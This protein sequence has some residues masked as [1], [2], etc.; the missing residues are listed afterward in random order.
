MELALVVYLIGILPSVA[1]LFVG[2][3]VIFSALTAIVLL[4][5]SLA[6]EGQDLGKFPKWIP[7]V[8]ISLGFVAA[9]L[10]SEKTA[11]MMTAAY[12]TQKVVESP[13]V[14]EVGSKL[15]QA[16]NNN[17]DKVITEAEKDK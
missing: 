17:L 8:A 9:I 5:Y 14:G 15:L 12:V 13:Q 1:N 11:Y 7:I 3:C 4:V 2:L 6:G 10:P 16:V